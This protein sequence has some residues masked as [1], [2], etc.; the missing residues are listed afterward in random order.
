MAAVVARGVVALAVAKHDC[1]AIDG[2]PWQ[3][4]NGKQIHQHKKIQPF[5][6]VSLYFNM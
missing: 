3:L 4:R 5:I 1:N 2:G 6:I